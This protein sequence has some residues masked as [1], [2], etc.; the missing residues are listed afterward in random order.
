VSNYKIEKILKIVRKLNKDDFRD[1]AITSGNSLDDVL[2][3][4][5]FCLKKHTSNKNRTRKLIKHISTISAGDF[6]VA[7][8]ISKEE[9]ELDVISMGLNIFVEE[10]RY[11]AISIKAFDDVFNSFKSP[12]FIVN[13]DD[14]IVT[15]FN[16]STLEFF[17]YTASNRYNIP[18]S[19]ILDKELI[20][21]IG[22]LDWKR[23]KAIMIQS[24]LNNKNRKCIVNFSKLDSTYNP[25]SSV[26]V[27]ITDVTSEFKKQQEMENL[28]FRTIVDTQ[29]K[30]RIRFAKDIHDSLGQQLSGISFYLSSLTNNADLSSKMSAKILAKS[31][32]ALKGVL[33]EIRDICFN[34][35]PKT[36]ENLGLS[37]AVNELSRKIQLTGI[38]E[39]DIDISV[40][41]PRLNKSLEIAIFRI[42]QEFIN[43]SIKH[44]RAKRINIVFK[45]NSKKIHLYMRDNGAGF[46]YKKVGG[47][48]GMGLK[49]VRSRVKSFNGEI[50]IT[51]IPKVGTKYE[52]ILPVIHSLK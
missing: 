45:N 42:I 8:P 38:L 32:E 15:K 4:L 3:E 21:M 5:T 36:L 13:T 29:E 16:K 1:R 39:F 18:V 30:E 2:N 26:A 24:T 10:L 44:G 52:I 27:L 47:H 43:N 25:V 48:S 28:V 22:S 40:N 11:N 19:Q 17:N 14:K 50:E 49:N 12:F 23:K 6:S 9:D 41:F 33:G 51:S 34:L 35:M 46:D 7:L 31:N 37:E 20:K